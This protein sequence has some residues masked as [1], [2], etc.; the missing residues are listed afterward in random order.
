MNGVTV[1][2]FTSLNPLTLIL[3]VVEG[4]SAALATNCSVTPS[5]ASVIV[6]A[7]D[8][9]NVI[10]LCPT[11]SGSTCV[12]MTAAICAFTGTLVVVLLSGL[13]LTTVGAV[14]TLL[15]PVV[16]VVELPEPIF[17]ATSA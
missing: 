10:A 13:M 12:L 8:G 15:V 3:Y 17:P 7:T 4:V 9:V 6:P 16:K 1:F 5:L 14:V 11:V 2:P